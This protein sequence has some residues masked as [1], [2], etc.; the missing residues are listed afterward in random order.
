MQQK[1]REKIDRLLLLL[2]NKQKSSIILEINEKNDKKIYK[3]LE[4]EG[5]LNIPSSKKQGDTGSR[6]ERAG[7]FNLWRK[8][9]NGTWTV[10]LYNINRMINQK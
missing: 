1:I 2:T 3:F 4:R 6:M 7:I 9:S 8:N 10:N 5:K